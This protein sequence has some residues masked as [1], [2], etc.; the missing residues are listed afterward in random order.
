VS[1][2][3]TPLLA[4]LLA[5][6][7][8]SAQSGPVVRFAG[9]VSQDG[10][11]FCCEFSCQ[12]SPTPTPEL[13]PQ[14]R[15]VFRRSSGHFLLV[16]E[17]GL[18]SSSRHVGTEGVFSSGNVQ[19]ITDPSGKPSLMALTDRNLG[20]G[21]LQ[22]DC[23]TE[24]IGGVRG[25]PALDFD[26]GGSV[27]TALADLA[28]RFEFASSA[29]VACTRDSFGSFAFLNSQTTRQ[30]CSQVAN[31]DEFPI[32]W[33]TVAVQLR[34]TSGNLGPRHEFVVVVD[35]NAATTSTPTSTPT[36]TRTP[37]RT[38]IP[39]NIAG[40]IRY[41]ANT[42]PVPNATVRLTGAAT[43]TSITQSTG[44]YL[45]A[46]LATG[47]MTSEPRKVGDFG[48]PTAISALDASHVLQSVA[49]MR[50]F[51]ARQ[52]LACDVTGNG[53]L[54][55]LDAA[56]ILQRVVGLL[57][58]FS[59]A[60]RCDSDWV[61]DPIAAIGGGRRLITP[62]MTS[63]SCRLGAIAYEPLTTDQTLQDFVG[64]LFGDCTGNWQP[65][66]AG[67][68][69][70]ALA[71]APDVRLRASRRTADGRMRVPIAVDAAGEFSAVDLTIALGPGLRAES[72]RPLRGA[73][74]ALMI[75]NISDPTRPRIAL[76]SPAPLQ[77]GAI[78]V[79][80]LAAAEG[81]A[82]DVRLL[83]ALVDDQPAI[84]TT[85]AARIAD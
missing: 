6:A 19:T 17:A 78:L 74:D 5:V 80:D 22:V 52:R 59:V 70:R 11:P 61:F 60:G 18:G 21:T 68:Q 71:G 27:N 9:P 82:P 3:F 81:A 56:H 10:C 23:R 85:G 33:T 53:S 44:A 30:F 2:V 45:H 13:D 77:P 40:S 57:P 34:D 76:A 31:A 12:G 29:T 37:T 35:P 46:N 48:S 65:A 63:T 42:R 36:A 75:Y 50:T 67:L 62:L 26:A 73:G 55:A 15:R 24:P 16:V 84:A 54:S 72:V 58:R 38:P 1:K 39:A 8:A 69:A 32:G 41:Y 43:R 51:D 83:R 20:N 25:F 4:L 64:I 14:G 66:A 49:G 28:C 79:L 7:S 47:T